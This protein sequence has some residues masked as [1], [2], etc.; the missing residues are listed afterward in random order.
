MS[1]H[2]KN[3]GH[4]ACIAS[5]GKAILLA[6]SRPALSIL[7]LALCGRAGPAAQLTRAQSVGQRD[8][9]N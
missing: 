5:N 7:G 4:Y 8:H 6:T 1:T 3:C 2:G 9:G